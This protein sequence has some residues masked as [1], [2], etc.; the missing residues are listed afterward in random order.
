MRNKRGKSIS[1]RRFTSSIL[2]AT[3]IGTVGCLDEGNDTQIIIFNNSS[4]G[5]SVSVEVYHVKPKPRKQIVDDDVTISLDQAH[6]Y[7]NLF[8]Q[9]GAKRILIETGSGKHSGFEWEDGPDSSGGSLH[10]DIGKDIEFSIT[11]D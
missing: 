6:E 10:V 3:L 1:R 5:I 7:N 9:F 4:S 2:S 8:E 11:A